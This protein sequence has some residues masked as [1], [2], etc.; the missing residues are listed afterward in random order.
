MIKFALKNLVYNDV[1]GK[2]EGI[3]QI[4]NK[5][6]LLYFDWYYFS[7]IGGFRSTVTCQKI[8]SKELNWKNYFS[9]TSQIARFIFD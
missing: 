8:Q 9:I 2:I 5:R 3:G 7:L 1:T 4:E 6:L